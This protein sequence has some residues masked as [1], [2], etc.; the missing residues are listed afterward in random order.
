MDCRVF[1]L[2]VFFFE[3]GG[4]K[5]CTA[6]LELE[7]GGNFEMDEKFVGLLESKSLNSLL[8]LRAR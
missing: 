8:I 4:D 2:C 6:L 7:G 1:V 3:G 5:T